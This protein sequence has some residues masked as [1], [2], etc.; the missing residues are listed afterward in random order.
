M[1]GLTIRFDRA[2]AR[3]RVSRWNKQ[4]NTVIRRAVKASRRAIHT[5]NSGSSHK[6]ERLALKAKRVVIRTANAL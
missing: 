2:G 4:M 3:K 6:A 5:S 1:N